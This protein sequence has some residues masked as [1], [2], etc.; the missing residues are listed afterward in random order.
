MPSKKYRAPPE[1][2]AATRRFNFRAMWDRIVPREQQHRPIAMLDI[3]A[4]RHLCRTFAYW[5]RIAH[6]VQPLNKHAQ[7]VAFAQVL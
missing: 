5:G 2:I 3:S 1:I 6:H 7:L 4:L